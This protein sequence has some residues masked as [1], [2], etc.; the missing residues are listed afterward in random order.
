MKTKLYQVLKDNKQVFKG[1]RKECSDFLGVNPGTLSYRT[2]SLKVNGFE[3]KL[4]GNVVKQK[5]Q[6][7]NSITIEGIKCQIIKSSVYEN[8][9]IVNDGNE[10]RVATRKLLKFVK[11]EIPS[12][13][14]RKKK[15]AN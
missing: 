4:L 13:K 1:N 11:S 2:S 10:I 5:F 9:I 12:G 14:V 3:L 6:E 8:V 15:I 7:G